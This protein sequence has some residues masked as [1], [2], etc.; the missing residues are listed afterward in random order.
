MKVL[1]EE[2]VQYCHRLAFRL[3]SRCP[4]SQKRGHLVD[5]NPRVTGSRPALMTL[6]VSSAS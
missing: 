3:W 6:E 5:I 4:T 1:V 2:V